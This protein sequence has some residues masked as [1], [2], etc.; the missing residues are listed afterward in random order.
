MRRA[1]PEIQ[2]LLA[3]G[4]SLKD[5]RDSLSELGIELHYSRLCEYVNEQR[6]RQPNGPAKQVALA[7]SENSVARA[8]HDSIEKEVEIDRRDPLFNVKRSMAIKRGFDFKPFRPED[9]RRLVGD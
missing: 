3:A 6:R 4:H 1:W 2:R 8:N 7:T 5:V 9:T